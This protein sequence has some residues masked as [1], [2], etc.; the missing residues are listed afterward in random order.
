MGTRSLPGGIPTWSV[1]T[2]NI[3]G[4]KAPLMQMIGAFRCVYECFSITHGIMHAVT[5]SIE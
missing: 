5:N 4:L 2:I 3:E 1:G